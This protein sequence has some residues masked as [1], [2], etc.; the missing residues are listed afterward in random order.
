MDTFTLF[1]NILKLGQTVNELAIQSDL[2]TEV[3]GSFIV[4]KL[5][6]H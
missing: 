3:K 6:V 4:E 1:I 5:Y 2:S